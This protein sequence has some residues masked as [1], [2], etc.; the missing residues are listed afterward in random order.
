MAA[1]SLSGDLWKSLYFLYFAIA[2]LVG[3]LVVGWLTYCLVKFRSRPGMPKPVDAPRAGVIT[4]ERGH[5]IWSYVMAIGI[6]AIMFG[7]AFGTISAATQME[8]PPKD[9]PGLHLDVIGFQFGWKVNYVGEG[10]IPFQRVNEWTVPVDTPVVM[11]VTSQDVW[12]NFALTEYRVRIDAIPGEVNRIWF[13]G[14]S[15]ATIQPVCVQI[16]G[17]GHA[18]MKSTM[19]VVT[20]DQF[21]TYLQTESEKE[22]TRLAGQFDRDASRGAAR[23]ATV[24]GQGVFLE[25]A[26]FTPG[27]PLILTVNNQG[28]QTV[29]VTVEGATTSAI[30]PGT[31]GRLYVVAPAADSLEVTTSSGASTTLKAVSK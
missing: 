20:A 5:P 9:V 4:A 30:A 7:L 14:T 1:T 24:S 6:A 31:V 27:K 18:L 25:N 15:L 8:V 11:N 10:G 12:H 22:Y 29:T 21:A 19:H 3:V 2:L 13:Q 16:C 26:T 28:A 17:T 23:N